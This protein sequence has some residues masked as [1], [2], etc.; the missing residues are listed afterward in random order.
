MKLFL[1]FLFAFC[2]CLDIFAI[3]VKNPA[4]PTYFQQGLFYKINKKP[5]WG[6]KTCCFYDKIYKGRY[7]DEY[8][9]IGSNPADIELSTIG[10]AIYFNMRNRLDVVGLVGYSQMKLDKMFYTHRCPSWGGGASLLLLQAHHIYLTLDGKYFRTDQKSDYFLCD[11][12][13]AQIIGDLE[14]QYEEIQIAL[15]LGYK[16]E[17]LIP[18]IGM[19]YLHSTIDPNPPSGIL[20]IPGTEYL[21]DYQ[22]SKATSRRNWGM[23]VG[24]SLV[25]HKMMSLTLESRFFDQNAYHVS[26][27]F[28]F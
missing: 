10:G 11:E 27:T 21:V 26:G 3:H 16:I 9:T 17:F 8:K 7:E 19:T 23:L 1:P 12:Q 20:Q 4:D 14:L 28:R 25:D 2:F 6:I 24:C 22:T 13:V 5:A 18:Y 15:T